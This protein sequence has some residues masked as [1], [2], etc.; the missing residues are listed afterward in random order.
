MKPRAPLDLPRASCYMKWGVPALESLDANK[1]FFDVLSDPKM[2]R[3][4]PNYVGMSEAL[5]IFNKYALA[6]SQ[7]QQSVPAAMTTAKI[8]IEDLLRRRPQPQ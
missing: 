5:G 1:A 6:A 2:V 7:G 4:A 8:E 3:F